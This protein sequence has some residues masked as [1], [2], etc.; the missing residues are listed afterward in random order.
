MLGLGKDRVCDKGGFDEGLGNGV[1]GR[2]LDKGLGLGMWEM[3]GW[4]CGGRQCCA[5]GVG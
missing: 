2:H 3:L 1:W 5:R 4:G